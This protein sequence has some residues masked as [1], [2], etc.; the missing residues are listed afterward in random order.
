M[1]LSFCTA[2]II[3][4]IFR[5]IK[6]ILEVINERFH[7]QDEPSLNRLTHEYICFLVVFEYNT[8]NSF[9]MIVSAIE[10]FGCCNEKRK[11]SSLIIELCVRVV[12]V[13]RLLSFSFHYFFCRLFCYGNIIFS[14]KSGNTIVK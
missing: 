6:C 9:T 14:R 11:V 7:K 10:N 1:S 12:N 2:S 4:I 8:F 5:C 3:A 13:K